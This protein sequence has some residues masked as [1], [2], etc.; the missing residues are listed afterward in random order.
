MQV[1]PPIDVKSWSLVVT[2]NDRMRRREV[3]ARLRQT[4][5]HLD[6]ALDSGQTLGTVETCGRT[7]TDGLRLSEG[8]EAQLLSRGLP[9]TTEPM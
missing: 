7:R 4:L 1:E 5:M 2:R 8:W 3:G 6:E 9:D